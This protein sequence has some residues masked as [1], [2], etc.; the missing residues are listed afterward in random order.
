M[1]PIYVL[2]T[3]SCYTRTFEMVVPVFVSAAAQLSRF[4]RCKVPGSA[5]KKLI[6]PDTFHGKSHT[7]LIREAV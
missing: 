1:P 4:A 3:L 7:E 5:G 6:T 2:L